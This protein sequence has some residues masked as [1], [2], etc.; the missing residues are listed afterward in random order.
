MRALCPNCAHA[1][2][3]YPN[4]EHSFVG[5]RCERCDWDGTIPKWITERQNKLARGNSAPGP[6]H[7]LRKVQTEEKVKVMNEESTLT[8]RLLLAKELYEHALGHSRFT[9]GMDKMIAVHN[10]HNAIEI[11][12]RAILFSEEIRPEREM[13]I[14]FESMIQAID[15][16]KPLRE[17]NTRL[18]YRTEL[19]KLNTLRNLVQHHAHEPEA[20]T[21]D[22]W[23]VF[24]GNFLRKSCDTYF[25]VSFDELS[26]ISLVEDQ[27]LRRI[28]RLHQ[29]LVA[30]AKLD[31]AACACK[32]AFAAA[33][34]ALRETLPSF[35]SSWSFF[36]GANKDAN[37]R[38]LAEK[39]DKR[40]VENELY[41]VAVSSGI[42]P[43]DFA[44]FRKT[45]IFVHLPQSGK[46]I[47]ER[48]GDTPE[49]NEIEWL[50]E[51][52][53]HSI[54]AWQGAGLA[55]R[56]PDWLS[57]GCDAYLAEQEDGLAPK[58]EGE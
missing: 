25:K 29:P 6:S 2:Y 16:H 34:H 49:F 18:P 13:N 21:M 40:F 19:R 50:L 44:R 36:A 37:I 58:T 14:T 52:V 57:S 28:L 11:V 7:S 39:I 30:S 12:L 51:F 10:F 22:E 41:T 23:R 27:R 33:N 38:D 48:T 1:L 55:P 20:A 35:R 47:F 45:R 3:G 9:T 4:C 8:R 46:P 31:D 26:L 54:V 15:E 32:F 53:V 24:S 5:G 43:G 42:R 56:V 17:Q